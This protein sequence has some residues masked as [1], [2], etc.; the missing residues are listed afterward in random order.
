MGKDDPNS[1]YDEDNLVHC[2]FD[3]FIAGTDTT[4]ASLQWAVLLMA[5][6][7]DIQDN[8]HK[9]LEEVFGSS[10][11]IC[12]EDQKKIPY[13]NAVI[14]EIMR[15]KYVLLYGLSRK[16]VKDVYLNGF[17]IPKVQNMDPSGY[18]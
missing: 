9:E 1:T 10:H 7:L 4:T 8:V 2:I 18:I 6:H 3:L 15:S 17:L 14:H 12:Y 13:T 16:C 11:S 5:N